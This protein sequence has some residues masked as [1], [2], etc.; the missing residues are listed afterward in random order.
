MGIGLAELESTSWGASQPESSLYVL[1]RIFQENNIQT[2]SQFNEYTSL[3]ANMNIDVYKQVCA[4]DE[5][6]G[7]V[8]QFQK[9]Q[10]LTPT[11][12]NF[13]DNS[14]FGI[15]KELPVPKTLLLGGEF[16]Y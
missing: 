10:A 1:K 11:T 8:S 9:N 3:S 13:D 15:I 12:G 5:F 7:N 2:W 16:P 6:F 4:L 14:I